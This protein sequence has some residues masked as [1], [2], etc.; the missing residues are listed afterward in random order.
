[1]AAAEREA[2]KDLANSTLLIKQ[3][4]LDEAN[5]MKQE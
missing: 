1:M 3:F 4:L 2:V 5:I